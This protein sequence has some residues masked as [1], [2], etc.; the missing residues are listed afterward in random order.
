M[1]R[2]KNY[3]TMSTFVKVMQKKLWPLFFPDTVYMYERQ[4][5]SRTTAVNETL[6]RFPK[7]SLIDTSGK[8]VFGNLYVGETTPSVPN[9]LRHGEDRPTTPI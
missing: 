2:A 6:A 5:F 8:V 9:Y 3:E 7:N 4:Q 1:V